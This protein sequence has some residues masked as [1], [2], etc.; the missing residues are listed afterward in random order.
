MQSRH[1]FADDGG[2]RLRAHVAIVESAAGHD[3]N[4]EG[5]EESRPHV[6][7]RH[8][9]GARVGVGRSIGKR[10]IRDPHAPSERD[11]RG[12][13]RRSN[14]R[15]AAGAIEQRLLKGERALVR[16]A[17]H[18]EVEGHG[19]STVR[20]EADVHGPRV[21][22]ALQ[23]ETGRHQQDQRDGKLSGDEEA[24]QTGSRPCIAG[25]LFALEGTDWWRA[26][27]PQGRGDAKEQT[28][29]ERYSERE[30][31][32]QSIRAQVRLER[33]AGET[34]EQF[35]RP[36]RDE[37]AQ[38]ATASGQHAAL[39]QVLTDEPASRRA[40]RDAN[41]RFSPFCDTAHEEEVGDIGARDEEHG[42]RR[43]Q[44][45]RR[46]R[47]RLLLIAR[48]GAANAIEPDGEAFVRRGIR[49]RDGCRARADRGAGFGSRDSRRQPAD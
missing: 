15:H 38:R 16:V 41:G 37:Q 35:C 47:C 30:R 31:E 6:V 34:Q 5:V 45:N 25:A 28:G 23:K 17:V 4:A 24:L 7:H 1:G 42:H 8:A 44:Q 39:N 3:R 40:E 29:E 10:E 20:L 27:A 46:E 19:N 48:W 36:H 9:G 14:A 33:N 43:C 11:Q 12:Q 22:Q 49:L 32:D 21:R 18:A 26:G 2:R 13:R